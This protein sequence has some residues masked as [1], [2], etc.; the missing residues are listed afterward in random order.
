MYSKKKK[1]FVATSLRMTVEEAKLVR[2]ASLHNRMST[3][4]W[5]L[6]TLIPAAK[7]ELA[8]AAKDAA[9]TE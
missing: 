4:L 2:E 6:T 1:G 7:K 9:A 8:K 3:N 5:M